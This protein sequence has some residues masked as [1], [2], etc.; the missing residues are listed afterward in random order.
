M[1]IPLIVNVVELLRWPGRTKEISVL[2]KASDFEFV[3][4]RIVDE[5]VEISIHL[6]GITNGV[7]V[8]GTARF[9]WNG[10]CR[11]CLAPL[12]ESVVV[13]L[14]ELYQPA[15]SDGPPD[16][17]AFDIENDQINLLPMVRENIL[18]SVPLGPL[19]R[20]DCRGFCPNC[21]ADLA[22]ITC[23]CDNEVPDPRWSALDQ[24]RGSLGETAE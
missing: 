3:D 12:S 24:I 14:D 11:R 17:D 7:D 8:R 5:P 13:A 15:V 19:C 2:V 22:Q 10:E 4:S 16:P 6:E 23:D 9:T 20:V 1:A 21:G 18:L